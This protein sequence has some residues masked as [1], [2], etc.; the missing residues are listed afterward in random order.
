MGVP[1]P[2]SRGRSGEKNFFFFIDHDFL[3][4]GRV[5]IPRGFTSVKRFFFYKNLRHDRNPCL[6]VFFFFLLGN[7]PEHMMIT[8]VIRAISISIGV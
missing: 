4:L 7:V 1:T 6:N 3:R 2:R 5:L 8:L